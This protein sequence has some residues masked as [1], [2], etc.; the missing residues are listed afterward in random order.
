MAKV[1]RGPTAIRT[2]GL[3]HSSYAEGGG[4]LSSAQQAQR[5][6]FISRHHI[7]CQDDVDY[8]PSTIAHRRG[9]SRNINALLCSPS[10][11]AIFL[12]T[13]PVQVQKPRDHVRLVLPQHLTHRQTFPFMQVSANLQTNLTDP[14]YSQLAEPPTNTIDHT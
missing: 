10:S 13:K 1:I 7:A 2:R 6:D 4:Y 9:E 14:D 12:L 5:T 11:I 8:L 3:A